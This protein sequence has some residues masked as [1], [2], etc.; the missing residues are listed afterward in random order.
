MNETIGKQW[1]Q[2]H[3]KYKTKDDIFKKADSRYHGYE[4]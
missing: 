2:T 1:W 4:I 3:L